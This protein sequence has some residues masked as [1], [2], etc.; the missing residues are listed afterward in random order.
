M[1][2]LKIF[3]S[4]TMTNLQ[5]ERQAVEQAIAEL[6][7]EAVRAETL[8][9][10]PVSSRQACLEMARQCDIYLGI[11][12]ARY[13]WVP[14]GD[15]VS[16][17]EMEFQEARKQGRDILV[18]VKD[19]PEREKAQVEFL[20]R[21]EDF[22]EGYFRRPY[23]TTPQ[24]LAEWVKEDIAGLVSRRY[25]RGEEAI[26]LNPYP[27]FQATP[28]RL[29]RSFDA[30]MADKIRG[31]VGRQFVFDAL[32]EFLQTHESG[33]FIIRGVC[34]IGKTALLAKLV[35]DRGHIHH[36]NIASQNIR[37]TRVFLEN[38]CAQ[39]IARYGLKHEELPQ[40]ATDDSGF[41]MQCLGEAAANRRNHPIVLAIDALDEVD[42][43]GLAP[44]VNI[45][46]L[47]PSLP[48]GVYVIIT[49]R[50]L[51]DL[52]LRVVRQQVLD[53]EADSEGNLRDI[54]VYIEAYARQEAMRAR[55]SAWGVSVEQF[56]VAL[57]KK[58]QGNFM[59]LRYVLPAIEQGK[60]VKGTLDELPEGLMAY[61]QGHWRKMREGNEREFDTLYEPIVCILGVAQEPVTVQ[62]IAAWTKLTQGQV[63]DA[64]R[65]WREFLEE[66]SVEGEHCYRIYHTSFQDF[67]R[68]Q[69]YLLQ[70]DDMITDYYLE[71]AERGQ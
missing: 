33:Y 68:E 63:K 23:F 56:V 16:V 24:E 55:L 57:R 67:L 1:D 47:P 42:R 21:V 62:Q 17:T 7:L 50:H 27:H 10:Q 38:V 71:L 65:L 11:Y 70:Y 22:D 29:R 5:A 18:Y 35:N 44:A 43:L 25:R 19:V 20:R 66:E 13:G 48:D 2:R 14:P 53:L 52:H 9:S 36:F 45:L 59:Y 46:Y 40:G 61:Y 15:H 60:F 69:V 30:L 28:A 6:R 41:L 58:S 8:G 54:S 26:G 3:I 12:G 64:I 49:T 51:D 39:L 37:S 4:S 31:F 32:D 34:G